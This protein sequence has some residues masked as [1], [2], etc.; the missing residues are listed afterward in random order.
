MVTQIRCSKHWTIWDWIN[1]CVI[2]LFLLIN[3]NF[4]VTR[5]DQSMFSIEYDRMKWTFLTFRMF[6]LL[7]VR[8]FVQCSLLQKCVSLLNQQWQSTESI[9]TPWQNWLIMLIHVNMNNVKF[10]H[11]NFAFF[12]VASSRNYHLWEQC[13]SVTVGSKSS[14]DAIGPWCMQFIFWTFSRWNE[15]HWHQLFCWIAR[16]SRIDEKS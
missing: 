16:H 4:F 14:N 11:W 1:N 7:P 8:I 10:L 6:S 2:L 5:S 9:Q 3:I 12:L 13:S 15:R